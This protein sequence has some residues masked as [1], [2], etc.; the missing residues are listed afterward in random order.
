MRGK[1]AGIH[2]YK[3]SHPVGAFDGQPARGIAA[4]RVS[5]DYHLLQAE[6]VGEFDEQITELRCAQGCCGWGRLAV[7]GPVQRNQPTT[8]RK[9]VVNRLEVGAVVQGGVAEQDRRA[10]TIIGVGHDS[11]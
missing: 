4:D 8:R 9:P 3:P 11:Q 10:R 2:Q 6:A 5:D 1:A 7:T